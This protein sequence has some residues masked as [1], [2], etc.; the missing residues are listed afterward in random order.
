M[1]LLSM[2]NIFFPSPL[3]TF[4]LTLSSL[5]FLLSSLFIFY[6]IFNK[7]NVY[8][9]SRSWNYC[10]KRQ[11]QHVK[12]C[13]K[14]AH[15]FQLYISLLFTP[16]LFISLLNF[17]SSY[18]IAPFTFFLYFFFFY[19]SYFIAPFFSSLSP[20]LTSLLLPLS[21]RSSQTFLLHFISVFGDALQYTV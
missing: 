2:S 11:C 17:Y 10:K 7:S 12:P 13:I 9:F 19:S 8:F 16:F 21:S 1:F 14:W 18:S 15:F 4:F 3:C 6:K 5:N 20:L